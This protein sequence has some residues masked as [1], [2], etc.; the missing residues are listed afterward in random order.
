M[1]IVSEDRNYVTKSVDVT[2]DWP[3]KEMKLEK[4]HN[5]GSR[6]FLASSA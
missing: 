6:H 1:S 4:A 5:A 2:K 3:A